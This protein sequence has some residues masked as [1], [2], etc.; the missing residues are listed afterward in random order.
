MDQ[1]D[2]VQKKQQFAD[3]VKKNYDQSLAFVELD[4]LLYELDIEK[5][6]NVLYPE[7][8]LPEALPMMYPDEI[9]EEGYKMQEFDLSGNEVK[10]CPSNQKQGS[11]LHKNLSRALNKILSR[12]IK[13][14]S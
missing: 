6:V 1:L 11:F 3:D 5:D 12:G 8:V 10:K 9:K 4:R 14:G 7:N 2:D 13:R